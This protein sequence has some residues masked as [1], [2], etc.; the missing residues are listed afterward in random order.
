M[1]IDFE[2]WLMEY[3]CKN[4]PEILDDHLPDAFNDWV[5]E[6]DCDSWISIGDAF[7]KY[8]KKQIIKKLEKTI[9]GYMITKTQ[10]KVD[11]LIKELKDGSK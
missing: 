6:L 9:E 1:K 8:I 5:Q 11:K 10:H 3:H 7:G 2:D 4:Y